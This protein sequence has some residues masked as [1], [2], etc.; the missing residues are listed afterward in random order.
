MRRHPTL[1]K[2]TTPVTLRAGCGFVLGWWPSSVFILRSRCRG[3]FWPLNY[4]MCW[5][6]TMI[7]ALYS[8]RLNAADSRKTL[9]ACLFNIRESNPGRL[10]S[11]LRNVLDPGV[12]ECSFPQVWRCVSATRNLWKRGKKGLWRARG[13]VI[14]RGNLELISFAGTSSGYLA[15]LCWRCILKIG[16]ALELYFTPLCYLGSLRCYCSG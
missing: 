5:R 13:R 4:P 2:S 6:L 8:L 7:Y 15:V 10:L 3:V 12:F 11:E 9:L 14:I 16:S 1:P